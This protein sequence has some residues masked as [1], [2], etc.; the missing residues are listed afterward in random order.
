[1]HLCV[2]IEPFVTINHHDVP[3]ELE[4]RYRSWLSPLIQYV[5]YVNYAII[6][7]DSI[8]YRFFLLYFRRDDFVYFAKICFES[9]GDRVT[10]WT[11]FNEPN[12][13]VE[14]AYIRGKYPPARCS[15]P[16]GNCSDGNSDS[17]PLVAMH[18]I[19][20]SHA[21]AAKIYRRE[22]KV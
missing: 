7:F 5:D 20:L 9:F 22:F 4:D 8:L 11:T 1:M 3:Q 6:S 18:N 10:H 2:G 12:L 16:F 21:L 17:E 19:L 15:A 14:M 13:L